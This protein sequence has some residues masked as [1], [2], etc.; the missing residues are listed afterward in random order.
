MGENQ[1]TFGDFERDGW[2]DENLCQ[3]YHE[4][5]AQLTQQAIP[6]LLDAAMVRPGSTALDVATGAGYAAQAAR[7][8]GAITTGVDFSV[9]Q[10]GLAR[11]TYPDV[12]FQVGNAEALSFSDSTYDAV[13]SNFGILHFPNPDQFLKEAFRILRPGGNL[14][15]TVWRPSD[16][17]SAFGIVL[18]ALSTHGSFD[19]ELPQGPDFFQ[20]ADP[21][22]SQKRLEHCGFEQIASTSLQLIWELEDPDDLCDAIT[23]AT[24]RT[25]A[26]IRH[27]SE[28]AQNAIMADVRSKV[29]AF[30][31]HG[32]FLVPMPVSL[33]RASRT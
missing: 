13:F 25:A 8:R 31:D 7:E 16:D 21:D 22:Y 2:S 5:F 23:Q 26:I 33:C 27:Q 6:S 29:R 15:F 30:A 1:K 9:T 17:P 19:V 4:R 28:D 12:N 3:T 18:N 11:N 10:I 32:K 20:F 14:A 24:V